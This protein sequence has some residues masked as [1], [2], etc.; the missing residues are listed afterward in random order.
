MDLFR[1]FFGGR[2]PFA[3]MF[4]GGFGGSFG[5][6]RSA[7]GMPSLFDMMGMGGMGGMGGMSGMG[8]GSSSFSFSSFGGGPGFSRSVQQRTVYEN[9]KPVTKITT[10]ETDAQGNT[11]VTIEEVR[12]GERRVISKTGDMLGAAPEEPTMSLSGGS[13]RKNKYGTNLGSHY[14]ATAATSTSSFAPGVLDEKVPSWTTLSE[15]EED[16]LGFHAAPDFAATGYSKART[17]GSLYDVMDEEH[18]SY[19]SRPTYDFSEGYYYND[20]HEHSGETDDSK[21]RR[22]SSMTGATSGSSRLDEA[23]RRAGLRGQPRTVH[24]GIPGDA[25][26]RHAREHSH[27]GAQPLH[28]A[29][30][31][32]TSGR[33]YSTTHPHHYPVRHAEGLRHS[34]AIYGLE[35]KSKSRDS[36]DRVGQHYIHHH[37]QHHGQ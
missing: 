10:E 4:M 1:E 33:S 17:P 29:H 6:Q 3:E 37:G 24:N 15:D 21:R 18:K 25:P 34:E 27:H 11:T 36:S 30:V 13:V 23:A 19:A 12:D 35:G 14:A 9:G 20:R 22:R 26:G 31:S 32:S 8:G 2:D 28:K 5:N 16:D 7:S